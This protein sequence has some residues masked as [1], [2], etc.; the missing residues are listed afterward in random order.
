MDKSQTLIAWEPLWR[1]TR[2]VF[3]EV[4][5]SPQD[6][7]IEAD[8]L[9]WANL[10][11]VDSHGVQRIPAYVRGVK[12]G[13]FK[14]DAD[15][16]IERETSAMM[17]IEADHAFGPVVTV[18]AMQQVMDKAQEV[19]IGWALIRNTT[20]QGAMGYYPLMA[21]KRDMIGIA[22][23]CNPPNMAPFGAKAAGVHNSP[24]AIAVPGKDHPPVILDMATSVVARGKVDVAVD[25]CVSIPKDW[26]LDR[27]G[28]PTTDPHQVAVVMPFGGYKASGLALMFECLSSL[29]VGNPLLAPSLLAHDEKPRLG[30]QNSV[31]AALDIGAWTDVARY[32]ENIDE[33]VGG[34]KALPKADGF[35]EILVPGEPEDRAHEQR[36]R[37]GIPLPAG[38]MSRLKEVA[39]ELAVEMPPVL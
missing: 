6:A 12:K 2:D 33:L 30:T 15:I 19:G 13:L 34:L 7:G 38:T 32:K 3:V 20:H 18:Y 4:G 9:L 28:N 17:L 39:A 11:G 10:R 29:M 14:P 27:E 24:I 31:V 16:R 37:H 21:A 1:F 35:D 23:V 22:L 8:V 25:K 36:R 5:L 26:G